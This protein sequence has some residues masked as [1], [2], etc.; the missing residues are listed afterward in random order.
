LT[1][2]KKERTSL[3]KNVLQIF[4]DTQT[5]PINSKNNSKEAIN[6]TWKAAV[7]SPPPD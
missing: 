5:A 1:I 4:Y 6:I 3:S 7:Y 2:E